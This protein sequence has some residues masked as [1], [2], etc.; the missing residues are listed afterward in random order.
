MGE[1]FLIIGFAHL[2]FH[3]LLLV[4]AAYGIDAPVYEHAQ[5]AVEHLPGFGIGIGLEG[6]EGKQQQKERF[7]HM[8]APYNVI[9]IIILTC[10]EDYALIRKLKNQA[11]FEFSKAFGADKRKK[12]TI[13]AFLFYITLVIQSGGVWLS[14]LRRCIC[15]CRIRCRG[16]ISG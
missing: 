6:N 4:V 10:S 15:W 2:F 7:F 16:R 3:P 14:I 8:R 9:C 5:P 11:I 13:F 1:V 12:S